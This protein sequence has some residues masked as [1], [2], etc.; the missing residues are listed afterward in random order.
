MTVKKLA[1]ARQFRSIKS[2]P[3]SRPGCPPPQIKVT[4][5]KEYRHVDPHIIRKL[6][7][8]FSDSLG[9]VPWSDIKN[10]GA[11]TRILVFGPAKI[12]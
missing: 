12:K 2:M 3:D 5:I 1:E 9:A 10:T 7:V 6:E 11:E 8:V 4:L